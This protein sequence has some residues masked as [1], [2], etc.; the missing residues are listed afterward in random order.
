MKNINIDS[1]VNITDNN[2]KLL[3][4]SAKQLNISRNDLV[5]K[6][7]I[8]YL[9]HQKNKYKVF[10]RVKYQKKN[11]HEKWRSTHV[12]FSQEFYE[13]CQNIRVF[14]KLSIS[15]IL[16]E[17]IQLFLEKIL[18]GSTDNYTHTYICFFTKLNNC[19]VFTILWEYPGEKILTKIYE[20]HNE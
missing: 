6:L 17:S 20:I 18:R 15:F 5:V 9:S 14:Y 10:S 13:K 8:A 7:F 3:E 4:K 2:L 19:P 11:E 12:W 16:A 1:C